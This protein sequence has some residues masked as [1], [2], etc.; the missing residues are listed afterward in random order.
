MTWDASAW[1]TSHSFRLIDEFRVANGTY[2]DGNPAAGAFGCTTM[3]FDDHPAFRDG[4]LVA[5]AFFEHGTRFLSI[6]KKG[7][8]S[9][10]GYFMPA[11]G[12]TIAAY[13]ITDEIVYAID[14]YRGIDILKFDAES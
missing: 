13:W 14:I 1:R 4:G 2:T 5:S 8:I 7:R 10:V 11:A 9:E 12:S 6:N 3:W